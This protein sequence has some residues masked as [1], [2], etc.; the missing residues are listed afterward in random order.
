MTLQNH[1]SISLSKHMGDGKEKLGRG[2]YAISTPIVCTQGRLI[3]KGD[4]EN[5]NLILTGTVPRSG[6]QE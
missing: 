6:F 4:F 2:P 3:L 1:M 5:K